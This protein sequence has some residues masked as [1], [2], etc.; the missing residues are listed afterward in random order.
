MRILLVDDEMQGRKYLANYLTL[1]GHEVTQCQSAEEAIEVLAEAR[2]HMV[3]SDIKMEGQSGIDLVRHIKKG[4]KADQPD[5]VLYTGFIDIELAIG[6]LR[7]GAYDYLTKPINFDELGAILDR[8]AEH[9]E[10]VRENALLTD[11]FD[12]ELRAA[13]A[14]KD[15]ELAEVHAMLAKQ[16]GIENLLLFSK[17]MREVIRQ[18]E[19]YHTDRSIP[20]LIQGETGV[21]KEIVAKVIHYGDD[22]EARPFIDINCTA[23]TPSLFESEL[24]GYEGGSFSGG[25]SRGQKGKLDMAAGG[26]LFLDEI[27]EIPV[28][29][30][31]K[32]LR[33]LEEK[34]FYRV[35]G[36][37]KIQTDIRVI[38]ATN[39]DFDERIKSGLFRR[40]LYYRLKVGH[41]Y[42]PPLRERQEDILNMGLA[43]LQIF[44][45]KRGKRFCRISDAA[46]EVLLSYRWPGNVRELRNAMEWVSFMFDDEELRVEHF[47]RLL[48]KAAPADGEPRNLAEARPVARKRLERA[49]QDDQMTD[50]VEQALERFHGNK[51][52]AARFLGI[53]IRTLY[54]RLERARKEPAKAQGS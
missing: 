26:S 54:Y 48:N 51:T 53:S 13:A 47:G 21:G 7:A 22:R 2:F 27:A 8:V 46:A 43:Y 11:H 37:K 16:A 42:V 50:V 36:L 9:Q 30:Q 45:R 39:L 35:G 41:I 31:A 6:A 17:P 19:Q 38:S 3:L 4:A 44:S 33:V 23:I 29:L 52:Q 32:L 28:E 24:F 10:L 18:A 25:Y 5:I 40:D 1:L 15:R 12:D 49:V 14:D 34:H 20:V